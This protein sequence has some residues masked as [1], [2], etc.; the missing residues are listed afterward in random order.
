M[1]FRG[2]GVMCVCEG[3]SC[4]IMVASAQ[5]IDVDSWCNMREGVSNCLFDVDDTCD[6]HGIRWGWGFYFL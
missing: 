4:C 1:S 3:V 2:L 5:T 6:E